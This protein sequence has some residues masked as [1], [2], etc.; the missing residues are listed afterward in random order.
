MNR[1]LN[2]PP[3]SQND[4]MQDHQIQNDTNVPLRQTGSRQAK[5][6]NFMEYTLPQ[7]E[8]G[9]KLVALKQ[10]RLRPANASTI[11]QLYKLSWVKLVLLKT[12]QRLHPQRTIS[13]IVPLVP[14]TR[15][16]ISN[17][18]E[19]TYLLDTRFSEWYRMLARV[20]TSK[21][22]VLKTVGN[23]HSNN[24]ENFPFQKIITN[25]FVKFSLKTF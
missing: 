16:T 13:Y 8:N 11:Y 10:L 25:F 3:V 22:K 5:S 1:S 4:S 17:D 7:L 21:G 15:R 14:V 19:N 23:A 18:N 9:N 20:L 2:T 6:V 24:L 12:F